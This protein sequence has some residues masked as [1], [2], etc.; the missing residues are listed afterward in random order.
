MATE[1]AVRAIRIDRELLIAIG[2]LKV[3]PGRKWPEEHV[4]VPRA[5]IKAMVVP[6]HVLALQL[7]KVLEDRR[8]V[9]VHDSQ[10][11][12]ADI[13]VVAQ[14]LVRFPVKKGVPIIAGQI[15]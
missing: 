13:R 11:A 5:P 3:R 14:D 7:D 12:L 6:L 1:R 9:R 2:R 10:S 4:L 15:D 8:E